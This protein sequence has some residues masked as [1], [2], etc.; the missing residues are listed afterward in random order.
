[1]SR[2]NG[3]QV[4][5]STAARD[6]L[7]AS[8]VAYAEQHGIGDLSLRE[9]AAAIGTSH[10]MLIYHFGSKEGLLVEVV[11]AVEAEQRAFLASLAADAR[12]A[13]ADAIRMMWRRLSDPAM[14]A[15]ERLFYDVYV[16]ALHGRLGDV[17]FFDNI[18][19]GWVEVAIENRPA[20]QSRDEAA[21]DA[22]LGVAVMRGLLLDLL[23][24][25]DRKA[26]NAAAERY[27]NL[28]ER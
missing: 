22:R 20:E 12:P 14:A 3:T 28:Y 23:A 17:N 15:K 6:R 21:A 11:K 18:V 27:A 9:L 26:V 10:R 1:V 5:P 7:L 25:G 2:E 24:T 8:A 4:Q 19:E 13:P 16:N